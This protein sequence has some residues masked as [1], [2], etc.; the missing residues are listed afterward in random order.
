MSSITAT[1]RI[2][3]MGS[4]LALTV[5][6]CGSSATPAPSAAPATAARAT[7]APATAA[8]ASAAEDT[9][10]PARTP[11]AVKPG[12]TPGAAGN[13]IT[14]LADL[15][16]YHLKL[17]IT[18]TGLKG[19]LAQV[20]DIT[21]DGIVV[22]KPAPAADMNLSMG[23]LKVHSVEVNG[24][25]YVDMGSGLAEG[26][27]QANM[28]SSFSPEKL[29]GPL[30]SYASQMTV[31]GDETKNGIATT[32]L[33]APASMLSTAAAPLGSAFGL[34]NGDWTMDVW[35]AKDGGYAVSYVMTGKNSTANLSMSMDLSDINSPN[36]VVKA[37]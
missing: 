21:M 16:S 36:N 22:A 3:A 24:K 19:G 5:V 31:V 14:A 25:Q 30:G 10:A 37:P 11:A 8:P 35:V 7:A 20:G 9:P 34:D 18:G 26:S 6:A 15:N 13:P 29:F 32:H 4:V 17:A 23:P 27:G 2:I 33:T 28:A 12:A 1:G